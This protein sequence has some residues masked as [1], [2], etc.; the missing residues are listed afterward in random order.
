MTLAASAR[1]RSLSARRM[2]SCGGSTR[3][4][5]VLRRQVEVGNEREHDPEHRAPA[6]HAAEVDAAAVVLH[7]LVGDG[8]AE[9]GARVLGREE[10]VEDA[11][12]GRRRNSRSAVLHLEPQPPIERAPYAP[13]W[14]TA[15]AP[16]QAE[17]E[18]PARRHG[19]ERV[20]HQ[21]DERPIERFLVG[22][23]RR[24]VARELPGDGD[25]AR[26]DPVLVELHD[27]L[28]ERRESDEGERHA[29]R[30]GQL[31]QTLDD[32]IDALELARHHALEAL[33]EARVVEP[34]RH[35]LMNVRKDVSGFLISWARPAARVPTAARRSERRSWLSS[36]RT[37]VRS[38]RMP[39][40]PRSL[41]SPPL[42]G[43]VDSSTGSALPFRRRSV[44][45]TWPIGARLVSVSMRMSPISGV[46]PNTSVQ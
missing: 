29:R 30:P 11:V 40:A 3:V 31:E 6:P 35:R 34:A 41:P 32:P 18:S 1:S 24:D 37:T 12:G 9:P 39:T 23:D 43:A 33:A 22:L 7:D 14:I 2:A 28:Q 16:A 15:L 42:S 26:L 13:R 8:Q 4:V 10:R 36:W 46:S 44:S 5:I 17:R 21:V 27:P 20:G 19:V 25:V 38:R 45:G